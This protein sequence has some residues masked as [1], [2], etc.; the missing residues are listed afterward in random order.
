MHAQMQRTG[1]PDRDSV[2]VACSDA[3]T[4]VNGLRGTPRGFRLT[5]RSLG[6]S[7]FQLRWGRR[8]GVQRF[9]WISF[10]I[11][12]CKTSCVRELRILGIRSRRKGCVRT[13]GHGYQGWRSARCGLHRRVLYRIDLIPPSSNGPVL[14]GRA[15]TR[16]SSQASCRKPGLC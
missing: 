13:I 4:C 10:H 9:G 16:W 15:M 11:R 6:K 5:R 8:V 14:S 3:L 12:R 2:P 1:E 7:E